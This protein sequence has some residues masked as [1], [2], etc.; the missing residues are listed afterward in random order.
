[1]VWVLLLFS[2]D[3]INLSLPIWGLKSRE[4]RPAD[5]PVYNFWLTDTFCVMLC[6]Q[7]LQKT[8]SSVPWLHP[9][10]YSRLCP[11]TQGFHS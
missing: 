3:Q 8:L 9:Q 2:T 4:A 7:T 10:T 6:S 5:F 1:M 11:L